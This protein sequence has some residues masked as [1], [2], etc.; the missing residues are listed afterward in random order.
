MAHGI[1]AIASDVGGIPEMMADG[2]TGTIH[3]PGDRKA[4]ADAI[5]FYLCN[6]EEITRRGKAALDSVLPYYP[7]SVLKS[8]AELYHKV[9]S[10]K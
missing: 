2:I 5:D 8:V 7:D 1:P 9:L 10:E 3:T 4:I 6:P